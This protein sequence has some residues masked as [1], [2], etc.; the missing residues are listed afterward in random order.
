[1]KVFIKLD[2]GAGLTKI[3]RKLKRRSRL[4]FELDETDF[5]IFEVE[6]AALSGCE[7]VLSY[8]KSFESDR[9]GYILRQWVASN[10]YDRISY[11]TLL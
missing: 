11:F 10:L 1:M 7:N 2:A 4:N 8:Q 6:R 9:A 3:Q 5:W